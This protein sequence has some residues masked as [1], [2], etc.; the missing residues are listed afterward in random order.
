MAFFYHKVI[1][2]IHN[3]HY[4]HANTV[5]RISTG[6]TFDA[7]NQQIHDELI[8]LLHTPATNSTQTK[9]RSCSQQLQYATSHTH[10]SKTHTHY[11]S[12]FIPELKN[13]K[14]TNTR[15]HLTH[16]QLKHNRV[17]QLESG[18]TN[19]NL[20]SYRTTKPTS[21]ISSNFIH[22]RMTPLFNAG[23]IV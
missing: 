9:E 12:H 22:G 1:Y 4:K 19:H 14:E 13:N 5:L 10:T 8:T 7:N 3:E 23:R 16:H 17:S 15:L 11:H 2:R 6:C 21:Y 18:Q 20:S